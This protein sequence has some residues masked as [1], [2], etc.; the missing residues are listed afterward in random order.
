VLDAEGTVI[1]GPKR[2][3]DLLRHSG[4]RRVARASEMADYA[5]AIADG[6]LWL[7]PERTGTLATLGEV[8]GP[9]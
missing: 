1:D 8:A 2:L 6:L 4:R 3:E 9:E 7:A 5:V